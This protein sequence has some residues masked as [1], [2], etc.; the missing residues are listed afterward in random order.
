MPKSPFERKIDNVK[1][2]VEQLKA[3]LLKTQKALASESVRNICNSCLIHAKKLESVTGQKFVSQLSNEVKN[4][5]A[6]IDMSENP[7]SLVNEFRDK[8]RNRLHALGIQ[9]IDDGFYS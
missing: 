9:F 5:N 6:K 1:S 2:E 8:C 7:L 4:V 3:E